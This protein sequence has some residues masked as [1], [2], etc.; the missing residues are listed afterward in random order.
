M[1]S[2]VYNSL[3][4][5]PAP[6]K[7]KF[8]VNFRRTLESVGLLVARTNDCYSPLA[9]SFQLRTTMPR[10]NRPSAL[11]GVDYDLE[12]MKQDI[13]DLLGKYLEEF[14]AIPPHTTLQKEGFGVGYTAVDALTLYMMVRH[15]K[16]LRYVEVGSGLSTYYC[17]LAAERNAN[18]GHPLEMT[19]I[20]PKPYDKLREI[21][22]VRLISKE[23]QDVDASL[24]AQLQENDI[25]FIDSSHILKVDGDVPFLYLE[26]LPMLNVGVTIHVHDIPFPYNIPYP[27]EF[28][29][30]DKD[31]PMFWNEAML[32]QAFFCFN[33]RFKI[34]MSTSLIRHFDEAFLNKHIPLYET[35]EQNPN[36]FS[37]IWLRRV[38]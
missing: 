17:S 31:W 18:E 20:E 6:V 33:D 34:T 28:W 24:F 9:S 13:L 19:C 30:L 15:L 32:L 23:V 14:S 10:W 12:K 36:T 21:A 26:V 4:K 16:P 22:G 38:C 3:R 7:H 35:V 37:S 11:R 29:I 8:A 5:L 2:L 25:L 1:K 27:P